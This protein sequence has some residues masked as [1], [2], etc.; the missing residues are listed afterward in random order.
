[1]RTVRAQSVINRDGPMLDTPMSD[2][3]KE[4]K[5]PDDFLFGTATA[6]FQIEGAWNE[7]GNC[8]LNRISV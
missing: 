1:M 7:E 8:S 5:F 6:A 2:A 3:P 4:R